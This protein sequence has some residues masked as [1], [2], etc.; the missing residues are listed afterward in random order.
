MSDRSPADLARRIERLE[1]THQIEQLAVRY[2]LAVDERDVD[3]FVGLFIPDVRVGGGR[4]GRD[5]L[6]EIMRPQLRLFYRSVHLICGHRIIFHDDGP[7]TGTVYCRAEHEVDDRWIVIAVRYDD[8]YRK[9]D[10]QWLF[11][12]RVDKHLYETDTLVRP[13][14]VNFHGWPE[15][16]SRPPIPDASS[17]TAFWAAVDTSEVTRAPV[18]DNAAR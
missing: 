6:R 10:G 2:A 11:A 7:A 13:Q 5:A 9:V 8:E 15:A 17:W 14:Q 18:P 12:R 16:P 4:R 3:E 1:D